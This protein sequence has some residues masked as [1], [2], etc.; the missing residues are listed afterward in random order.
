MLGSRSNAQALHPGQDRQLKA[1]T[2]RTGRWTRAADRHTPPRRILCVEGGA[3]VGILWI[4]LLGIAPKSLAHS[5][6]Q[7]LPRLFHRGFSMQ[8]SFKN[9][10]ITVFYMKS[11]PTITTKLLIYSQI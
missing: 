4:N 2:R 3:P 10:E 1:S 7:A 5:Y 11:S 8:I 6:P 9:N